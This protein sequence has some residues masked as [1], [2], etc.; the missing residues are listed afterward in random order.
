MSH[1]FDIIIHTPTLEDWIEVVEYFLEQNI[2]WF[3]V[4]G[5]R[6][7]ENRWDTHRSW[8]CVRVNVISNFNRYLSFGS[9]GF[10]KGLGNVV[11][12]MNVFHRRYGYNRNVVRILKDFR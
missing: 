3:G 12:D 5:N 7:H 1:V 2:F 8:T 9:Y 10:Y 6:I 4:P 11:S